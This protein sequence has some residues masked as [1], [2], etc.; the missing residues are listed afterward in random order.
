M[1]LEI[2]SSRLGLKLS[3]T[4][5]SLFDQ[6]KSLLG[7]HHFTPEIA[8]SETKNI[9][10]RLVPRVPM[11]GADID[12]NLSLELSKMGMKHGKL[13]TAESHPE[14]MQVW[15]IMS[16]RAGFTH[17]PQLIIVESSIINA[18]T[19][20]PEEV[21]VTTGLLKKLDLR[22]V[23]AVLGHELGHAVSAHKEP[24][25]AAN[26]L[27]GGGGAWAG[28]K[29]WEKFRQ[30]RLLPTSSKL[31]T[32][33]EELIFVSLGGTIGSMFG[34]HIAV[35]PT[36]FQA[37]LK[38]AAIS[39]DPLGLVSALNKLESTRG[40]NSFRALFG[41]LQSGYP[42]TE[43]RIE[44]LKRFASQLPPPALEQAVTLHKVSQ[45]QVAQPGVTVSGVAAESRVND[46]QELALS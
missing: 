27:F 35:K 33:A 6:V 22:E 21:V 45:T 39:G 41:Y 16:Q 10:P 40:R 37:D 26:I 23:C 30:P 24:R 20:S 34:N 8:L 18:M 44:N 42:T 2:P 12:T 17:A 13:V 15:K 28:Y 3:A 38:G 11:S 31:G 9:D 32:I 4:F 14:L 19:V 29:V 36:E 5:T 46:A 25:I 43:Q 7:L 1:D